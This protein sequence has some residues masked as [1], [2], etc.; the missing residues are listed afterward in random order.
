MSRQSDCIKVD[1]FTWYLK[2]QSSPS[3]QHSIFK[4]ELPK[5]CVLNNF[6]IMTSVILNSV[7]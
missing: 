1:F 7:Y 2:D 5:F 6:E 4:S 3:M